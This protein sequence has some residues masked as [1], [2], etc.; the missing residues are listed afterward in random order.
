MATSQPEMFQKS[1][2]DESEIL[3]L[4]ENHF[5]LDRKLLR[6]HPA[7][8]EDIPTPNT[9]KIVVLSSFFQCGFGIPT[10]EFLHGLLHHYQIKLVHH[11]P[12]STLQITVFVYLCE[13]FLAVPPNFPLFKSYFFLK[14]Q[15]ST[16]NRMVIG[17]VEIQTCP[18]SGFLDL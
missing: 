5:L 6:W 8:G 11:N 18:C 15:P 10:C 2:V 12:N 4:I 14:C 9:N 16:D 7:K 3:K 17:S 13:A 1:T